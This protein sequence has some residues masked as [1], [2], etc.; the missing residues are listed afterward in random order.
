M[1]P[2]T[3]EI[4]SERLGHE[5]AHLATLSDCPQPPPAVTRVV[6]TPTDLRARD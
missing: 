2:R 5:L 1:M 6:F 4:D 3:L